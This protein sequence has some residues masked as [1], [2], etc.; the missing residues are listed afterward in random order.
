MK[1]TA[2]IKCFSNCA[3][4]LLPIER[5]RLLKMKTAKPAALWQDYHGRT[6]GL[7]KGPSFFE[8]VGMVGEEY[9]L[10]CTGETQQRRN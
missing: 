5:C 1:R 9:D 4:S 3:K 8:A 6:E 10:P 7:L 2:N